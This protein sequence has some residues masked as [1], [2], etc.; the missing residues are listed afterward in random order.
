MQSIIVRNSKTELSNSEAGVNTYTVTI[1]YTIIQTDTTYPAF[2]TPRQDCVAVLQFSLTNDGIVHVDN[3]QRQIDSILI[4]AIGLAFS[5]EILQTA[6][7]EN[8]D[9]LAG[10][11]SSGMLS[12]MTIHLTASK[13]GFKS[14]RSNVTEMGGTIAGYRGYDANAEAFEH[15]FRFWK[16]PKWIRMFF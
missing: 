6:Q 11:T 10:R 9:Y 14:I 3:K 2:Q 8:R 15:P 16:W 5:R 12:E 7:A 13:I 4:P 1:Q